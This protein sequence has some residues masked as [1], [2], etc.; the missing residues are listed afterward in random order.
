MSGSDSQHQVL[1]PLEECHFQSVRL[2][3]YFN[4]LQL[5]NKIFSSALKV[6]I[7][8]HASADKTQLSRTTSY[9]E[10]VSGPAFH[11]PAPSLPS[12]P[13]ANCDELRRKKEK[14]KTKD[15]KASSL[16]TGHSP[17]FSHGLAIECTHKLCVLYEY[18]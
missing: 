18:L 9:A 13:S 2:L 10:Q 14:G 17:L 6:Q 15:I 4:S 12:K 3:S 1:L 7:N 5:N 11:Y 8:L 16:V